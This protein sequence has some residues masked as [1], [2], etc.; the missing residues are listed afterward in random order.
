M[1]KIGLVRFLKFIITNI[2]NELNDLV[3]FF[4][5]I[6]YNIFIKYF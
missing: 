1:N 4:K 6:E 3:M 5:K 2:I